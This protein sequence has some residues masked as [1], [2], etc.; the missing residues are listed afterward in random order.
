MEVQRENVEAAVLLADVVGSTPLYESVG[1]AVAVAQIADWRECMCALVRNNGGEFISSKGDDVLSIFGD[2]AAAFSAAM[3]MRA[4]TRLPISFHAGL[5][6]GP[7]IRMGNDI[8]GDAVNLTARLAAIANPGEVLISQSLVDLLSPADKKSLSFLDKMTFKGKSRPCNIY[9]FLD[10][11]WSLSTQISTG[12]R[13]ESATQ[14]AATCAVFVTLRYNGQTMCCGDNESLS[15][16]RSPD[17]DLVI[18]RQ[19]VSR[20]HATIGVANGRVRL[21]ER[22]SFGTF[23]SMRPGQEMLV[24]REDVLLLGSGTISPGMQCTSADAQVISFE[25]AML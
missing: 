21:A 23:L 25:I 1:N 19:W 5:H 13:H 11:D 10:E 8:Y 4:P 12:R 14:E 7:I 24:R 9:T 15:I 3:Q 6:F 17:C 18:N 22:S 20:R 16:G 2:P